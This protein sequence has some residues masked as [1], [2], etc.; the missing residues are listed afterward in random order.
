[1]ATEQGLKSI[2]IQANADL[3]ASQFCMGVVNSS[4]KFA[5]AGAGAKIDGVLQNK[6]AA[7]GRASTVAIDGVTK[8][9][10]GAAV[11]AGDDLTPDST[12]RAVTA[13]TG[14][15]VGGRALEAAT[16]ANQVITMLIDRNKKEL[17]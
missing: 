14:D 17:A 2:S 10:A 7:S 11:T 6:P 4:G 15:I 12:G 1:M 8:V 5:I 9:R 16:A 13:A 3:S